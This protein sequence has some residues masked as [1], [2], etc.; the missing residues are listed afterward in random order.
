MREKVR[1]SLERKLAKI[2]EEKKGANFACELYVL[3]KK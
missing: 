1:T 3:R 2:F